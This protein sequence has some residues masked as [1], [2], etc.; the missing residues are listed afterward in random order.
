ME[1]I[2]TERQINQNPGTDEVRFITNALYE[3]NSRIVGPDNHRKLQ[4]AMY[5]DQME[6]TIAAIRKEDSPIVQYT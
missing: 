6:Q 3:Y 2:H 1:E 4:R 5:Y